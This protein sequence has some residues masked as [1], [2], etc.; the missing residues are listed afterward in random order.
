[1]G[2]FTCEN[3]RSVQ[4]ICSEQNGSEAY[5]RDL[6]TR[7]RLPTTWTYP[8]DN[9]RQIDVRLG[10]TYTF[11][12]NDDFG[13][14][15]NVT[16]LIAYF[17]ALI[18]HESGQQIRGNYYIGR[19][20]DFVGGRSPPNIS[21]HLRHMNRAAYDAHEASARRD[22]AAVIREIQHGIVYLNTARHLWDEYFKRH[23]GT[24]ET[25]AETV[26]ITRDV[27]LSVSVTVLSGGTSTLAQVGVAGAVTFSTTLIEEVGV[28]AVAGSLESVNWWRIGVDS[29]LA[30]LSTG[31]GAG[32]D[33]LGKLIMPDLLGILSRST[34][35]SNTLGPELSEAVLARMGA[36][37]R[38]GNRGTPISQLGIDEVTLF[39]TIKT[40]LADTIRDA[41]GNIVQEMIETVLRELIPQQE[42]GQH[43][44]A[45]AEHT[46]DDI[47]LQKLGE[48]I[49]NSPLERT[50]ITGI[51]AAV[52]N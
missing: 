52:A 35:W 40:V 9:T 16:A 32:L 37:A 46:R 11:W 31:L 19:L 2:D 48:K 49:L 18:E 14:S 30:M 22:L 15:N 27:C 25:T 41:P 7:E 33:K 43:I 47:F 42:A 21:G 34:S 13:T 1:M 12:A 6:G 29:A 28:G 8:W 3:G 38:A 10:L 4:P 17:T 24:A 45:D 36:L 50:I 39:T 44:V 23:V 20:V 51:A 5:A 26:K